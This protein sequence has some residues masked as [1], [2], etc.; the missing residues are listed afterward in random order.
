MK[1]EGVVVSILFVLVFTFALAIGLHTNVVAS[2]IP[3][4]CNIPA[5]TECSAGKGEFVWSPQGTFCRCNVYNYPQCQHI[6]PV[7]W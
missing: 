7:C 5:S 6:C 3:F 2:D 4:C 1:R